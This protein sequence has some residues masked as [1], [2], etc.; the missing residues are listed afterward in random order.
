MIYESF[1]VTGFREQDWAKKYTKLPITQIQIENG[2][3]NLTILVGPTLGTSQNLL[4]Q[5]HA[6]IQEHQICNFYIVTYYSN[7]LFI[8]M[9]DNIEQPKNH[10]HYSMETGL[11]VLT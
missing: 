1:L 11:Y 7:T 9:F 3:R 10:K 8:C 4:K 5:I 2:T 6:A